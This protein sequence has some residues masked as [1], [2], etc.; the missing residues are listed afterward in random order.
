MN[1]RLL[2]LCVLLSPLAGAQE[3]PAGGE[4]TPPATVRLET[5]SVSGER[6]LP[7]VMVI[8]PWK[9]GDA[10]ATPGRPPASLIDRI[11]QPLDR[12]VLQ[13]EV[14]YFDALAAGETDTDTKE[15]D[16]T[17][18]ASSNAAATGTEISTTRATAREAVAD[19]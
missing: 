9:D 7:K 2:L 18:E 19:Q 1:R 3:A 11:L 10:A 8:V 16:P 13:R 4:K 17:G 12:E 6:E 15:F 14:A 5:T